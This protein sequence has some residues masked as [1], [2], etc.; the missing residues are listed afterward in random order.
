MYVPFLNFSLFKFEKK[1]K[2]FG[3]IMCVTKPE[4]SVKKSVDQSNL[5][6]I[7]EQWRERLNIDLPFQPL[8]VFQRPKPNLKEGVLKL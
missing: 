3:K 8:Q 6:I 1:L 7:F 4:E 5:I 2:L